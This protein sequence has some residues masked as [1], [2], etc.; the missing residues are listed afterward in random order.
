MSEPRDVAERRFVWLATQR[1]CTWVPEGQL[2]SVMAVRGP[3]PDF[4]V[5]SRAG[6]FLAEVKAFEKP[7]PLHGIDQV[8]SRSMEA[9][10]KPISGAIDEARRQLR[11]YRGDA[12]P[13]LVVLD[14]WRQLGIDLSPEILIQI[15]G[16]LQFVVPIARQGGQA[17]E[18]SLA[19]GGGR[20][21]G[22]DAGTY[23]SAVLV[24]LA[25]SRDAIDAFTNERPMH[26]RIV[27]N[28]FAVVPLS[29]SI[30]A[31]PDDE[32]WIHEDQRWRRVTHGP[33]EPT[34]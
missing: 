21:I 27:H 12:I 29:T 24:N 13:M 22:E 18:T 30:F 17:G 2:E 5:R 31:N 14:P 6:P 33:Q 16:E 19:H 26:A 28:P 8:G 15:F 3:R 10:L 25:S 34:R 32:Q 23:L 20:T 11:P 4:Y 9:M 1:G 7:G